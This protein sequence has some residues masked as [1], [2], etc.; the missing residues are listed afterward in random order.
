MT[1]LMTLF[2]HLS[3]RNEEGKQH[4]FY[5]GRTGT[6]LARR[7]Q[8]HRRDAVKGV[9]PKGQLMQAIAK[10]G[11]AVAITEITRTN[12]HDQQVVAAI[13]DTLIAQYLEAGWTLA[14][15]GKGACGIVP[16]MQLDY[17]WSESELAML[18]KVSD[19]ELA[20]LKGC[21]RTTVANKRKAL[22]IPSG[23]N[24]GQFESKVNNLPAEF[25][26]RL[27]KVTDRNLADEYGVSILT[28]GNARNALGIPKPTRMGLQR[29]TQNLPSEYWEQLGK[30]P[31]IILA[32]QYNLHRQTVSR[33]RKTKESGSVQ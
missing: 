13:E 11:L 27:G 17:E 8:G 26:S 25:W 24:S 7:L 9:T 30:I 5:I 29:K 10:R 18:G 3:Y 14:N 12:T 2:Y 23:G 4:I 31:D 33:N 20:K 21:D 19:T 28:V 15:K 6:T 16:G 1:E 22:D 32:N